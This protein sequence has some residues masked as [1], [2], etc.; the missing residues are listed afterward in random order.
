MQQLVLARL[1]LE[2][3]FRSLAVPAAVENDDGGE[4]VHLNRQDL[5]RILL[6]RL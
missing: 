1:T 6:P 4:L 3:H 2:P 5:E